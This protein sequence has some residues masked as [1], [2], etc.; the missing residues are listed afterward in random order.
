SEESTLYL[1][2]GKKYS[3]F[4]TEG[5]AK[6]EKAR[7]KAAKE[8]NGKNIS[9]VVR[10][11]GYNFNK[12]IYKNLQTSKVYVVGDLGG[13]KFAYTDPHQLQWKLEDSSK[14]FMGYTVN[15]A[16]THF[17]GRDYVAWYTLQV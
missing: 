16:T 1:Y 11:V 9:M 8:R 14:T 13:H 17:A 4:M 2:T 6:R 15:K 10:L 3:V 5:M 7:E 12:T